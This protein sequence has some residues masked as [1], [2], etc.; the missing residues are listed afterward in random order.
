MH[1]LRGRSSDGMVMRARNSVRVMMVMVAWVALMMGSS[2]CGDS[3]PPVM[4]GGALELRVSGVPSDADLAIRVTGPEGFD[5]VVSRAGRI[6]ELLPGDYRIALSAVEHGGEVYDPVGPN[7]IDVTVVEGKVE[8]AALTYERLSDFRFRDGAQALNLT[9][10]EERTIEIHFL[11]ASAFDEAIALEI[12]DEVSGLVIDAATVTVAPNATLAVISLK[13][14][15]AADGT[16]TLHLKATSA[17]VSTAKTATLEVRVG[18]IVTATTDAT[19]PEPG[20]LRYV[21]TSPRVD[22]KTITF[23]ENVFPP[24]A[25]TAVELEGS[26][27]QI[28]NISWTLEGPESD[29][30]SPAVVITHVTPTRPGLHIGSDAVLHFK[31]IEFAHLGGM[32]VR[33]NENAQ[34][35]FDHCVFF[36]NKHVGDGPG[37]GGAALT[38]RGPTRVVVRNSRFEGNSS[39][40]RGGAV[41]LELGVQA[42]F[43]DTV[44]IAN[45]AAFKE[46]LNDSG[47]AGAIWAT[48][49]DVVLANCEFRDNVAAGDGGAVDVRGGSLSVTETLFENNEARNGGGIFV[50][51][52]TALTVEDSVFRENRAG[53][54][55]ALVTYSTTGAIR[56]SLFE[57]NHASIQ[58]GALRTHGSTHIAESVIRENTS[59]RQA[60][61]FNGG[62][63]TSIFDSEILDNHATDGDGGGVFNYQN[64]R[65]LRILRTTIAG[66][67]ATGR[68]G[69]IF[70]DFGAAIEIDESSL[71]HNHADGDGGA[72]AL[73]GDGVLLWMANTTI[74]ENTARRGAGVLVSGNARPDEESMISF[75][76]FARNRAV[77][78]GGGMYVPS[79]VV[80]RGNLIALNE[81]EGN[82][83]NIAGTLESDGYNIQDGADGTA[84]ATDLWGAIVHLPELALHMGRTEVIAIDATS[85]AYNFIPADQCTYARPAGVNVFVLTDQQGV[86]RPAEGACDA[87]AFE[88]LRM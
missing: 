38:S 37:G 29:T 25:R 54:G 80:L 87:G 69:G 76:T 68:G 44:F 53:Q 14:S 34:V 8:M 16:H 33:V 78:I 9:Y 72:L 22:G 31:R 63:F 43:Y 2:A 58:G 48:Q 59:P 40:L 6:E 73:V 7:P 32:G 13:E 86:E 74:V 15:G 11:R 81:A 12:S 26:V 57:S 84:H 45:Q 50:G 42:E 1:S 75:S 3:S 10:D 77:Q 23:D 83:P 47:R 20:Q 24:T 67:T 51:P 17:S 19:P 30:S 70:S 35:E 39:E 41:R 64:E 61:I 55:G 21:L 28:G 52:S 5:R 36:E 60:G 71:H 82:W 85:P 46:N 79:H 65:T 88:L 56:R 62:E 18:P 49:S 27:I 4:N 66:N